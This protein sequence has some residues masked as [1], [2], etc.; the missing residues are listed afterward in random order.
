MVPQ[1]FVH[2]TQEGF[3]YWINGEDISEESRQVMK[4]S[5]ILL[6]PTKGYGENTEVI[7]FPQ[8]TEEFLSFLREHQ[9]EG[10]V[11]NI[12]T[13]DSDYRELALHSE[14][15]RLA[16]IVVTSFLAPLVVNLITEYVKYRLGSRVSKVNLRARLTIVE[17]ETGR[18]TRIDYAGPAPEWSSNMAE[19]LRTL[20]SQQEKFP[21]E[22]NST[23]EE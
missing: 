18:A 22:N 3:A 10:S 21:Q 20:D 5:N 7:S 4:K 15:I 14:E 17:K 8:G 2:S 16:T 9:P 12:C 6:A 23:E 1:I 13:E 19:I 11:V